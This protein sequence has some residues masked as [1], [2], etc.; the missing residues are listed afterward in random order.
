MVEWYPEAAMIPLASAISVPA[1]CASGV[2]K[3]RVLYR[4]TI[5]KIEIT[6][7]LF[8]SVKSLKIVHHETIDYHLKYTDRQI[9]QELYA[10]RGICDDIIIV[11]NGLVTD[12]FAANLLFFDGK[13]WITPTTPLLKGTQRQFL[14]DRGIISEQEIREEEV[15]TYQKVGLINA[16]INFDEMPVIPIKRIF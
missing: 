1:D 9:L 3:V 2:Y 4:E 10:R 16:M 14:L 5:E 7:Y 6:P 13:K 11:K 8:R 15:K 12:S